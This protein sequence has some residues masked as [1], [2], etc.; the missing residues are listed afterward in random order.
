MSAAVATPARSRDAGDVGAVLRLLP[1]LARTDRQSLATLVLPVVA[2]AVTTALLLTVVAGTIVF[3][4]WEERDVLY[5]VLGAVACTLLVV[6]LVTLSGVA[7]RLSAR[8]RDD[9]LATLRLLGATGRSVTLIALIEST[10]VAA[11]GAIAGVALHVV[12]VPFVGLLPFG[13]AP[14][15]AG[16]LWLSPGTVVVVVV[17]TVAVA[18]LAAASGLRRVRITPLGVRAR[19]DAPPLRGLPALIGAAVIV[20]G[21]LALQ[22]VDGGIL[23]FAAVISV[24]LGATVAV[25]NLIGPWLLGVIG[26]IQ[27]RLARTPAQLIAARAVLEDP[28]AAWR[29]V[30][31]VAMTTFIAVVGG[32]GMS[33]IGTAQDIDQILVDIRVGVLVTLAISFVMVACTVG[34]TQASAV[35]DRR[36]LWVNL[37]RAGMAPETMDGA[38]R[39]QVLIPLVATVVFS[40]CVGGILV[41]P[42][43]GA[44]VLFAPLS[45]AV[46]AACFALGFA[47]ILG[48]LAASRPVL[49]RVL[50]DPESV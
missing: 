19:T 14:L 2:F 50:A 10:V 37:H 36:E 3:I 46:V 15:G 44:A 8:R 9:R 40:A 17:L 29:Q 49:R 31:G 25:L 32:A 23:V 34:V 4:A 1:L 7:A 28:K 12:L 24:V 33:L 16:A 42:L 13:G 5:P 43:I 26:R 38:R 18:A 21:F 30:S 35:L 6:P 45:L 22:V 47:S 20:A 41:L 39:R 11:V 27:V 48:A